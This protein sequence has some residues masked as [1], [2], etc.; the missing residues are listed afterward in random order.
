MGQH[1][2]LG[3]QRRAEIVQWWMEG[4]CLGAKTQ[5]GGMMLGVR[6]G[7]G[8]SAAIAGV[9]LMHE[10]E[11]VPP[12]LQTYQLPYLPSV[13][14]CCGAGHL[15]ASR[16][17]AYPTRMC[18]V[19]GESLP[20]CGRMLS[21][22]ICEEDICFDCYT[23]GAGRERQA[24]RRRLVALLQAQHRAYTRHVNGRHLHVTVLG[25]EPLQQRRGV[26]STLLRATNAIADA[27][28]IPIYL[29]TQGWRNVNMYERYGFDVVQQATVI[30]SHPDGNET[31][32]ELF[33]LL[34]TPI[35]ARSGRRYQHQ[36]RHVD[37][38]AR[39]APPPS[40]S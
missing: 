22:N 18:S 26:A 5:V 13:A 6:V 20:F 33:G 35:E 12:E 37:E 15:L 11:E 17:E 29:E 32:S 9:A 19:C 36:P 27:R 3:D 30:V 34:R 7:E 8:S 38:M 21:C 25:V 16:T 23:T 10:I 1:V 31:L 14:E 40:R 2:S 24:M 39:G 28:R 4:R